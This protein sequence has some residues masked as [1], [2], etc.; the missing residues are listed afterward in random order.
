M[1]SASASSS[2]QWHRKTAVRGT[3]SPLSSAG[4]APSVSRPGRARC[5]EA[6]QAAASASTTVSAM[7]FGDVAEPQA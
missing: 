7:S 3:W 5:C 1:S 6:A 2:P 4:R